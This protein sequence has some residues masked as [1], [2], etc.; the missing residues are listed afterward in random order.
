MPE[1]AVTDARKHNQKHDLRVDFVARWQN[2]KATLIHGKFVQS[3]RL[4]DVH[5]H[6]ARHAELLPEPLVR[7]SCHVQEMGHSSIAAP[8]LMGTHIVTALADNIAHCQRDGER[9]PD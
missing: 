1:S 8:A 5:E 7:N 6:L 3:K 9:L 4:C 2:E